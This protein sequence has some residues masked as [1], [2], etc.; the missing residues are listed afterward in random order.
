MPRTV[1]SAQHFTA[2]V[3]GAH[4]VAWCVGLLQ[5]DEGSEDR[6]PRRATPIR[7]PTRRHPAR[8]LKAGT[9]YNEITAWQHQNVTGA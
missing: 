8:C 1:D 7:E 4:F 3:L 9:N 5:R 6:S 2:G